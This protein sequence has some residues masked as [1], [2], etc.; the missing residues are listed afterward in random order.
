M[1]HFFRA[2]GA[3]L[4]LALLL[5]PAR[6]EAHANLVDSDPPAGAVLASSPSELVLEFTEELDPGFSQVELF[7]SAMRRLNAGPGQIDPAVPRRLRLAVAELPQGSYTALWRARSAVDGHVTEG[8]LPFG[9]GVAPAE[10][11]LLPPPG[12]PPPAIAPAP[13]LDSALR[14]LSLLAAT[15]MLGGLPFGLLV[16]LPLAKGNQDA[17][18]A[19]ETQHQ[20]LNTQ[21]FILIGGILLVIATLLFLVSQAAGATGVGLAQA[22]G[23]PLADLLRGRSGL[24]GLVRA[25]LALL[26]MALAWRLPPVERAPGRWWLLLVLGAALL[27]TFSLGSHAAAQ[28]SGAALA[29]LADWLHLAA[30]VLWLGGLPALLGALLIARAHPQAIAAGPLVARFSRL[31]L[32]AVA[33]LALTGS[34]SAL[35]QIGSVEQLT[36][37]TY[38]RALLVKLGLF[39]LL[40][41][42]AAANLLVLSPRLR[43]QPSAGPALRALGRTVSAELLLGAVVLLAVGVMTSVAPSTVAWEQQRQQGVVQEAQAGDVDLLLRVA[44]GVIGGNAFAVDVRDRRPGAAAVPAKVLLRFGMIGMEMGQLQVE[45][46]PSGADRYVARGSYTAMGGRWS[47]LVILRRDGFDDVEHTFEFDLTRRG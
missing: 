46:T 39:G 25:G 28:P 23:A 17:A 18:L 14:W 41:V 34:Y 4:L 27:L 33:V 44:P 43:G 10:T 47:L 19:A 38:G 3:A 9:I 32:L 45:A 22:F 13:P 6:A 21:N 5:A 31:A 7:D 2:F 20:T 26:I 37:T 11:G 30:L 1:S 36:G 24:L 8:N 29:L 35:Q 12:T 42:L 15:L 16:W 40:L